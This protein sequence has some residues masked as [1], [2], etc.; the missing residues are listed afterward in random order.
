MFCCDHSSEDIKENYIG[1]I[2]TIDSVRTIDSVHYCSNFQ[3]C[4]TTIMSVDTITHVT[5]PPSVFP[6]YHSI[7][8]PLL[9]FFFVCASVVPHL[10]FVLPFFDPHLSFLCCLG[11][12]V[13]RACVISWISSLIYFAYAAHEE[14]R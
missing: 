2:G 4:S 6:S 11:K 8:V 7:V 14:T 10:A 9:Q 1:T 12:V 5:K 13:L 3:Y